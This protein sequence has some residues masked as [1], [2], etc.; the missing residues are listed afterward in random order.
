MRILQIVHQYPPERIGGTELYTLALA[1]GMMDRGHQV[2]VFHRAPGSPGLV[3]SDWE[4]VPT[5]RACAGDMTPVS[6][7]RSSFGDSV[8]SAAFAQATR[9]FQPELVHIQHLKG[10]PS[11]IVR[12]AR[13]KRIPQICTLHDYWA[14]CANAQLLTNYDQTICMGPRNGATNCA[15]CAVALLDKPISVLGLPMLAATMVWRN[16]LMARALQTSDVMVA[17]TDFV[18][19]WFI[20]YGWPEERIRVIPHGIEPPISNPE[21]DVKPGTGLTVA[22]IG[23]LSWQKGVHILVEAFDGLQDAQLWIAG[24][25]TFD[26]A[27]VAHLRA[28]ASSNVHFLG[29]LAR[30]E[31]WAT[32]AQADVVAVPSLWYETFS[33]IV[34]EAFAAG[35]PVLASDLGALREA[36]RQ[37]QDGWLVQ[38]GDVPAWRRTLSHL[39]KEPDLLEHARAGIRPPVTQEEH[40]D[41][42]EDLYKRAVGAHGDSL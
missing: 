33:L 25:Q 19:N 3:L 12:H 10:L 37:G 40:L 5:Y 35:V 38:P 1:K 30:A 4:G 27:Y 11:S 28:L 22:Y 21:S 31:V 18:R 7:Y 23:G 16:R 41:R 2:A 26:P 9:Q 8:L 39:T 15:R 34:H 42:V 13:E 29:P 24:D 20:A 6:A 36:V 32:L 17:P 14:V